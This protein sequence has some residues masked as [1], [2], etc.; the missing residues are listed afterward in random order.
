MHPHRLTDLQVHLL[1]NN[2]DKSLFDSKSI[3]EAQSIKT[4][5]RRIRL[6]WGLCSP[7]SGLS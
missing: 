7:R 1:H 2:S 5:T 4:W 6:S 3:Q